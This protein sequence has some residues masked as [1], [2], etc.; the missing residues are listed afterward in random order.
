MGGGSRAAPAARTAVEQN[1]SA[2]AGEAEDEDPLVREELVLLD[3]PE[4]SFAPS[5]RKGKHIAPP[6]SAGGAGAAAELPAEVV[7]AGAAPLAALAEELIVSKEDSP[8]AASAGE[9]TSKSGNATSS[10][11]AAHAAFLRRADLKLRARNLGTST[12]SLLLGDFSF[13]GE[14]ESQR[15]SSTALFRI[16]GHESGQ[17]DKASVSADGA[18]VRLQGIAQQVMSFAVDTTAATSKAAS[19]AVAVAKLA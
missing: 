14:R 15:M 2:P 5:L 9:A 12:P 3:F 13:S 18:Q 7:E 6:A 17:Q 10:R 1:F 4:L 11:M 16:D 8:T 19:E